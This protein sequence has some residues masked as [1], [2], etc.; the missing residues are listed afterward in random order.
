MG[1]Q[2]PIEF[3]RRRPI[4]KAPPVPAVAAELEANAQALLDG[5]GESPPAYQLNLARLRL[6]DR[7]EQLRR[8]T[9]KRDVAQLT[10]VF[11]RFYGQFYDRHLEAERPDLAP[12]QSP[13]VPVP[14][15][16]LPYQVSGLFYDEE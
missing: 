13:A 3:Q 14:H 11:T 1:L 6:A 15:Y 2:E 9:T 5:M 16:L 12:P 7:F 8:V 4:R 10:A